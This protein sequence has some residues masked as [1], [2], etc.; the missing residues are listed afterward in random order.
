MEGVPFQQLIWIPNAIYA[1]TRVSFEATVHLA[2]E[3]L[4]HTSVKGL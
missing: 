4:L 3:D 2:I 1:S